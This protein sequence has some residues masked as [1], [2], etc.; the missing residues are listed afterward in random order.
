MYNVVCENK[1]AVHFADED[2]G[3]HPQPILG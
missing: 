1:A 2:L 3:H